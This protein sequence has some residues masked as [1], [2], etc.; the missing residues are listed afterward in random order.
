MTVQNTIVKNVYLGNGSTTVFPFTFECK[1]SE[2]IQLFIKDA[3]GNIAST[4]NFSIDL[5]QK[6]ITYPKTGEPLPEGQKLIILRQL[7]LHQL[8]NLLNQGPYYA[9]DVE[10]TFD[11]V[12]MMLQQVSERLGRSLTISVDIDAESSFNTIIPLEAGKTF[13][14]KD[15]GTGFE[16]TEDPGKVIDE[17]KELLEL[18]TEQAN[19]AVNSSK[20]AQI[21]EKNAKNSEL[22]STE[23]AAHT[24]QIISAGFLLANNL[25]IKDGQICVVYKEE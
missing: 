5:E 12:V 11:E 25:V 17:A 21:S 9:E 22:I 15:D 3:A 7:P 4:T 10:E 19:I 8:L 14:V 20:Q 23:N 16:V 18:N 13:R 24:E 6:K 1:K 2:H